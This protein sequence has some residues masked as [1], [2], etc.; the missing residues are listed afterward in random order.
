MLNLLW[1]AEKSE[2]NMMKKT[3][4]AVAALS[5]AAAFADIV[6][7][8]VVGYVTEPVTKANFNALGIPFT[9]VDGKGFQLN[10]ISGD[11]V[12]GA[13]VADNADQ[14]WIWNPLT[15]DYEKW[16]YYT[17]SSHQYDGW[18]DYGTGTKTFAEVHPTGLE[19]GS[20]VWYVSSAN[21]NGGVATFPGAVEG[22]ATYTVTVNQGNF[23]LFSNPY[24]VALSL[25]GTQVNWGGARSAENADDAD[26]VWIWLPGPSDYSK[27]YFYSDSTHLYDGWWDFGTGTKLF[28]DV[29]PDGLP[30]GASVWY[31]A[32]GTL[33]AENTFDVTFTN[34]ISPTAE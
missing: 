11:G 3:M 29:Y 15:S 23:N 27:W 1:E 32:Q 22:A 24:P 17:D 20:S 16:Y 21:S 5:A 33:G 26:Q 10:S 31:V 2:E 19:P 13:E 28:E 25:N 12:Y 4:M 9:A 34:P 7:S 18:W 6:S 30:A 14:I 8:D